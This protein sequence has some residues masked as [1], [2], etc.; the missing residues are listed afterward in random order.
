MVLNKKFVCMSA[1]FDLKL[2]RMYLHITEIPTA[3]E[4][5]AYAETPARLACFS[6]RRFPIL[7]D[8]SRDISWM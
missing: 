8:I 4:I 3:R 2:A 1:P 7:L 5:A 6:P